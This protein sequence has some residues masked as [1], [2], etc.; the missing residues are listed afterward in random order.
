MAR[1][2]WVFVILDTAGEVIFAGANQSADQ[3]V[4]WVPSVGSGLVPTSPSASRL[5]MM[6]GGTCGFEMAYRHSD[7]EISQP[8][9][10]MQHKDIQ[11]P[12]SKSDEDPASFTPVG[13]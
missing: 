3:F 7:R 2:S 12:F 5:V 9:N 6:L 8:P 1:A 13:S 10:C 11:S 4:Q